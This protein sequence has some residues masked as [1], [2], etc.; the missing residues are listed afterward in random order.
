MPFYYGCQAMEQVHHLTFGTNMPVADGTGTQVLF[1][2]LVYNM[3]IQ[4]DD[5]VR[6]HLFQFFRGA[7][8]EHLI[9][10]AKYVGAGIDIGQVLGQNEH[11]IGQ[12]RHRSV[13]S[14]PYD[15]PARPRF[16]QKRNKC[17]HLVGIMH[18]YALYPAHLRQ[19]GHIKCIERFADGHV[20]MYRTTGTMRT[21]QQSLV[22]QAVHIPFIF[23]VLNLLNIDT[24]AHHLS[25]GSVLRH[26]L[27]VHL[28][29][30]GCRTVGTYQHE[31]HMLVIS[32]CCSGIQVAES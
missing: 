19:D 4:R 32:L 23:L 30:P 16:L 24:P 15:E 26:C 18:L 8:L 13:T 17:L 31:G 29:N 9:C 10:Y 11:A 21:L 7:S 25:Q 1:Q 14:L 22:H 12:H 27:S 28:A 3:A 20:D 2:F 5:Q 6:A